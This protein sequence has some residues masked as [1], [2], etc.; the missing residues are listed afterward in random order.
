MNLKKLR[1]SKNL[2]QKDLAKKLKVER[3]T[4]TMWENGHSTP[5]L[6]TLKKIAQILDCTIDDLIKEEK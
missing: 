4:V 1:M 3:T 5:N 2:T 6:Q